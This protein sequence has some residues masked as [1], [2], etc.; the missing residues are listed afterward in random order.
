MKSIALIVGD[1]KFNPL[2]LR[3][4]SEKKAVRDYKHLDRSLVINAWKQAN[5][6]SVPNYTDQAKLEKLMKLKRSTLSKKAL[7]LGL[8][9]EGDANKST[10]AKL[11]LENDNA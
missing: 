2:I 8:E 6:F 7:E 5:G 10:I 9:I 1:V 11:I 3:S 4:V